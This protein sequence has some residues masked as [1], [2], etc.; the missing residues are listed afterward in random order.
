MLSDVFLLS[1]IRIKEQDFLAKDTES[2]FYISTLTLNDRIWDWVAS[3]SDLTSPGRLDR[4]KR[5]DEILSLAE[6]ITEA[7]IDGDRYSHLG[8]RAYYEETN[9]ES[10]DGYHPGELV[11]LSVTILGE[12]L[13]KAKHL[14][15]EPSTYGA[16]R[17]FRWEVSGL[18]YRLLQDSEWCAGHIA[19]LDSTFDSESK[20]SYLY[21][22]SFQ[23]RH[24][25]NKDHSQ[26]SERLC[27]ADQVDRHDYASKHLNDC[28]AARMLR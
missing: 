25:E 18:L 15:F 13:S 10:S 9:A 3:E 6:R 7:I 16:G 12:A 1:G 4:L 24:R 20:V 17:P 26:C 5:V 27:I 14:V 8:K 19:V 2:D 21:Y 23:Q 11:I 28:W 22:L